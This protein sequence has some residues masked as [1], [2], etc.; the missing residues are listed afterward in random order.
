MSTEELSDS[1]SKL[2]ELNKQIT[3]ARADIKVLIRRGKG[4]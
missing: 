3:E 2:V 4:T 1:V